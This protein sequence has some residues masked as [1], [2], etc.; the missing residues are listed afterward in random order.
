[1]RSSRAVLGVLLTAGALGMASINVRAQPAAMPDLNGVWMGSGDAAQAIRAAA[2]SRATA[3]GVGAE[4]LPE[5]RPRPEH[6]RALF[7]ARPDP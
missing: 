3:H 6:R 4:P 7:A 2:G 5:L 1:M